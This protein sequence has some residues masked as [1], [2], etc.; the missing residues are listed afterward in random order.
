MADKDGIVKV[1]VPGGQPKTAL[2]F[3]LLPVLIACE[4]MGLLPAQDYVSACALLDRCA[5]DWGVDAPFENNPAKQ[6]LAQ[7][8]HGAAPVLYGLGGWQAIVAHRWKCQ[9]NENAKTMAFAGALP[10]MNHNEI[11]GWVKAREQGVS[12]WVTVVLEDGKEPAEMQKRRSS[13][14][15]HRRGL[16]RAPGAGSWESFWSGCC[17]L[18]TLGTSCRSFWRR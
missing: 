17:R 16:R 5:L 10:E 3:M 14:P 7:S 4:S 11:L 13:R 18:R 12:R 1:L 9:I 6:Q 2:G 15:T 8:L